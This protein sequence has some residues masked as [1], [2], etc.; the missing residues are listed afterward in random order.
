V[1]S[2][3]DGSTTKKTITT[4]DLV[5]TAGGSTPARPGGTCRPLRDLAVGLRLF[6]AW[7]R[8]GTWAGVWARLQQLAGGAG[9][10]TWDVSVDSTIARAH[11]HAAGVRRDPVSLSVSH[12]RV[13]MTVQRGGQSYQAAHG[14]HR[15]L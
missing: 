6:R 13:G 11:Q 2:P 14:T 9:L 3:V 1:R 5:D 10:I 4:G 12:R 8:D 7:Q 15:Y